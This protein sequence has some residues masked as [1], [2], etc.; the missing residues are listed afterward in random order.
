MSAANLTGRWWARLNA[1]Y[2]LVLTVEEHESQSYSSYPPETK[3]R[4]ATVADLVQLGRMGCIGNADN[5]SG[6]IEQVER[7]LNKIDLQAS[8]IQP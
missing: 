4:D 5:L 7:K 6:R 3:V 1:A 8:M 2:E